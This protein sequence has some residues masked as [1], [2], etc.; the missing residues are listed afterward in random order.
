[1]S[2]GGINVKSVDGFRKLLVAQSRWCMHV[3]LQ[4]KLQPHLHA[5]SL[6]SHILAFGFHMYTCKLMTSY[7]YAEREINWALGQK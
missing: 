7:S 5:C 3:S 4:F 1:M 6:R 2:K